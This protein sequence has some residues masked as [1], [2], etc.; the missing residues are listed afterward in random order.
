ML[1]AYLDEIGQP[2]AFVHTSHR[3]FS[4]S[5]AFGYG[6]FFIPVDNARAFGARFAHLK[7]QL[8]APEIP[9][10]RDPNRWEKKGADLL[11]ALAAEER[12]ENLRVVGA[13]IS[14]LRELEGALFYFAAEKPIG[15][16]KETDSGPAEFADRENTAMRESLNRLARAADSRDEPILIMM[17][18]INEKSRKQ[19]LPGM[20]AHIFGRAH[21]YSEMRRIVEPPMHIDSQLSA[22]IQFADWICALVKRAIEYQLV[23]DSRYQWV[24][25]TQA[26]KS[27]LGGFTHESK[28]QLYDRD[29]P[30]IHHSQIMKSVRP[31]FDV[32]GN[33]VSSPANRNKLERV[34][35]ASFRE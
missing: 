34:R 31:V 11:F 18:Q 25:D 7:R 6:G 16:P 21:E 29:L 13:L 3:R 24:A 19:R 35:R 1:L 26:F 2:G 12:P 10:G 9:A 32:R 28:L 17:D 27:L 4:D 23:E 5:P 14:C 33:V 30:D 15:T 20:Y 8:F 22:N